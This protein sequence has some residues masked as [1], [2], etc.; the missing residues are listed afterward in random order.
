MDAHWAELFEQ[1]MASGGFDSALQGLELLD[2]NPSEGSVRARL[3][4]LPHVRNI[5]GSLHGGAIA[6]LVDDVGSFAIVAG[7][8]DGRGG[9]STDL[10]VTYCAPAAADSS[11]IV[12]AKVLRIGKVLAF[13]TVDV[14]READN[15]LVAQGRM[16]KYVGAG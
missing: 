1:F 3:K 14:R 8:K 2:V 11:V 10:N 4:V 7:D 16:T 13:V 15:Q 9:T 12:D 6:T 5:R